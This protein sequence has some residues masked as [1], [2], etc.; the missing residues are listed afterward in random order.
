MEMIISLGYIGLGYI[1]KDTH[2]RRVVLLCD[3]IC[4]LPR[5]P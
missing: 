5:F 4:V 3:H 2:D 1:H